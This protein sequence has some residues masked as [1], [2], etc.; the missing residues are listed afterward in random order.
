MASER[1]VAFADNMGS[2]ARIA[3]PLK[4]I[5]ARCLKG[6]SAP[7]SGSTLAEQRISSSA[8]GRGLVA[9][10]FHPC[11]LRVQQR[12]PIIQL[13][14]RVGAEV[15]AC[16][17]TR[18]VSAGPWAIGFIHCDAA[19]GGSGLLSIGETVIRACNSVNDGLIGGH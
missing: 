16:E 5:R 17:A 19:S 3:N 2:P 1:R 7:L 14:L 18:R 4:L 8:V 6:S 15:F 11:D 13:G 9:V 12:D 10:G